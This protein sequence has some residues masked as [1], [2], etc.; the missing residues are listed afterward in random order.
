[1]KGEKTGNFAGLVAFDK[2]LGAMKTWKPKYSPCEINGCR[3]NGKHR[4][5]FGN[6]DRKVCWTHKE[7]FARARRRAFAY[8]KGSWGWLQ[9]K[10]ELAAFFPQG[11]S[12]NQRGYF[13]GKSGQKVQG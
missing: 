1:M 6:E 12:R 8:K 3:S 5:S 2:A 10:K 4:V 7:F 13:Y 9:A 11:K